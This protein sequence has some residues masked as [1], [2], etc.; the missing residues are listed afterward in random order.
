MDK[1]EKQTA[2]NVFLC[3]LVGPKGAGKSCF[4]RRFINKQQKFSNLSQRLTR[5]PSDNQYND[6][7]IN[8]I[9]VYGQK[10]YLIVSNE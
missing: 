4:M 5:K 3:N 1:Y 10:K 9:T 8:T 6:Y 7:V 2:R